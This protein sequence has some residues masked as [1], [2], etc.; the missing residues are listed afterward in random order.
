MENDEDLGESF[1]QKNKKL[2]ILGGIVIFAILI[3]KSIDLK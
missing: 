3:A 2:I 1:F